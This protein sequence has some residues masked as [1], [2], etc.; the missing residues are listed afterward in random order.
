MDRPA[1][2]ARGGGFLIMTTHWMVAALLRLYPAAWRREYGAEL[3]GILMARPLG[4]RVMADVA[5]N[6]LW[7]RGRAAEPS[8][9][10]GLAAMLLVLTSFVVTGISYGGT[11]TAWLGPSPRTFPPVMALASGSFVFLLVVC[12]GWTHLRHGST[13][14]RSGLA[15]MKMGFIAGIPIMLAG[16]LMMS[17]RLELT[18]VDPRLPAPAPWAILIAPLARLPEFWIWGA[19]G[20]QLGKR[21][22]R[23]KAAASA[24]RP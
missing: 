15:A 3:T 7:Q 8:T 18:I 24:I 13:A 12:G 20:G 22:A 19:V 23:Q 6:G 17:G 4:P 1:A 2:K 14:P 5:V 9:I 16:A 10:L 11:W 21:I